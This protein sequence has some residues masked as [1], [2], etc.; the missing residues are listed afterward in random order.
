MIKTIKVLGPD[1]FYAGLSLARGFR[2]QLRC[3]LAW[4]GLPIRGDALYGGGGTG[5]LA[6]KAQGLA[7]FDPLDGRPRDFTLSPLDEDFLG[8]G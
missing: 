6:L 7:F 1:L 4:I 2:H 5:P 8:K 3:H